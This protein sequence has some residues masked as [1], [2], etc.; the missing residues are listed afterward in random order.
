MLNFVLRAKVT[1]TVAAIG[2]SA[3][4]LIACQSDSA[5]PR[6]T[7]SQPVAQVVGP[8]STSSAP[9]TLRRD[10][11]AFPT[12]D[13]QLT[14]AGEQMSDDEAKTMDAQLSSLSAAR[15]RGSISQAEYNRRVQE[16]RDIGAGQK[17]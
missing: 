10:Q 17:P 15:S 9:V 5:P 6:A 11:G 16:L 13:R 1:L 7:Q 8:Q 4:M 14:A 2:L 3:P 12:F